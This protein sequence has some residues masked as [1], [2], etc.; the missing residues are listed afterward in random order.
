MHNGGS[1]PDFDKLLSNGDVL[2]VVPPFFGLDRPAL[3]AHILQ[4]CALEH[5]VRVSVFYANLFLASIIGDGNYSEI[6]YGPT[7]GLLGE[8]FFSATAYGLPPLGL[9]L[10][11][12]SNVNSSRRIVSDFKT[13]I[14][15]PTF[16][17][18][19]SHAGYFADEVAK[20]VI[21]KGYKI[22]CCTT[23]FEQ[24]SSSA[25][26]LKRVKKCS[27]ETVTMIGGANCEGEMA[28]G[29]ASLNCGIDYIFS[30]ESEAV[31][32]R[33]I[34]QVLSGARPKEQIIIGEPCVDLNKIPAPVFTEFYE[35]FDALIPNSEKMRGSL[36]LPYEASRG[37]W[38]GQKKQCTFCG[39][40]G[41]TIEFRE[42][43]PDLVL[44]ELKKLLVEHPS[45]KICMMDNIMPYSYFDA[46]LPKL[47]SAIPSAHIFYEQ[48]ANLS[49]SKI[50][51]LKN[52]G[53]EVIQP[54]IESLST[55][56]LQRMRK[57]VTAGQN[58]RLL[59]YARSVDL[60]VHWNILWG[61]PL[62]EILEYTQMLDLAPLIR[63][64]HP[65]IGISHLGISR[66]SPYF[67]KPEE[68]G[69]RNVRPMEEY[70]EVFPQHADI[71]KIAYHFMADYESESLENL[72]VMRALK[73]EV[74]AWRLTWQSDDLAP[75]ML[76][77]T[78]IAEDQYM[79]LDTRAL[80]GTREI[81]FIGYEQALFAVT[82]DLSATEE[83]KERALQLKLVVKMDNGYV[84]LVT[85]NPELLNFFENGH[86]L[87]G[88][89]AKT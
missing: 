48:K 83:T 61:F 32:P 63:H 62:D 41:A 71:L 43:S 15:A 21:R 74:D 68:F 3:S 64:L 10:D 33:V 84:P 42:K 47:K 17:E 53:V 51:A 76:A 7:S 66:F 37:C 70:G 87:T 38:W 52:A 36:W 58:L 50:I 39:I 77:L 59:R 49:L 45:R 75:P 26:I 55:S 23:S 5:G 6:C 80:P 28:V 88:Y 65:P 27:P 73:K 24:T 13:K 25:A 12:T 46:L 1:K 40:N 44:S 8:R 18:L 78:K 30:G 4:A 89:P 56:M 34:K 14:D 79:L 29:I 19:E 35:Q 16:E 9:Q 2:I 69:I 81:Q 72:E 67:N 86:C 20:A 31:F 60:T 11:E 22:V 54:G 85:A 57:G 82:G